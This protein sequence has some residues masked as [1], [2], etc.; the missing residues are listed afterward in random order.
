MFGVNSLPTAHD[1]EWKGEI[2]KKKVRRKEIRKDNKDSMM[3]LKE[4]G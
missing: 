1:F 4:Y 2:T 3:R